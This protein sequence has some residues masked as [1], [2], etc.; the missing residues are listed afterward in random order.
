MK[1]A[2]MEKTNDLMDRL[3]HRIKAALVD[4][5][6]RLDWRGSVLGRETKKSEKMKQLSDGMRHGIDSA[7]LIVEREFKKA[8]VA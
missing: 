3:M 5:Q 8:M 2:A 4:E 7:I 1:G 6:R